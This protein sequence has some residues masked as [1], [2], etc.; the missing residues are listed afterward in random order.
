MAEV[1][2]GAAATIVV[3]AYTA[4]QAG[5]AADDALNAQKD[6]NNASIREQQRQYDLTRQDNQPFLDAGYG[7]LRR[8]NEFLNGDT[9]GF[10]N[11]V[12]YQ[13]ALQQGF[14]GLNRGAAANGSF[15]SGGADADRIAYG[16]GLASQYSNNYWDKLR[17]M[18][19]QGQASVNA[20][21]DLGAN[22]AGDIGQNYL[23]IGNARA[24]AYGQKAD[25]NS[26]FA[27]GVGG[28]FN[29]WYSNNLAN[30]PGGTGWYV[31][32]N[33]GVG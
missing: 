1:W 11:S 22:M 25:A 19:G 20:L 16:Q 27:A 3:G 4:D 5:D 14:Q 7:A 32:N 8:Q 2:V 30:N 29:N 6:A 24:S 15:G 9:S 10:E 17:G 18:T 26:Q 33:P 23:N 13:W 12:D 28:A 21:G 31:G